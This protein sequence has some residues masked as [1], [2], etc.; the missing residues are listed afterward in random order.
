VPAEQVAGAHS[1]VAAGKRQPLAPLQVPP[2]VP[3][4]THSSWGSSPDASAVQVP[5]ALQLWQSAVHGPSQHTPSAQNPLTHIRPRS[6]AVAF[7]SSAAQTPR[8]Q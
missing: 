7:P 6:Q 2:Q 1:S 4:P 8:A 3:L 5:A